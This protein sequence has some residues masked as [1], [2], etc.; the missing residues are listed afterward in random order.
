MGEIAART[1]VNQ[2]EGNAK[3]VPE[4]VVEPEFVVRSSTARRQ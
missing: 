1:V 2:I 4:I 3:Y